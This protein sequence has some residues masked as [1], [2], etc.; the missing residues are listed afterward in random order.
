MAKL[1][2][3]RYTDALGIPEIAATVGL[4]PNYAM[5]L[6][7]KTFGMSML[8]YL[9]QHRLFH[10]RRLLATT[11][12]KVADVAFASGFGSLNRFYAIFQASD[13]CSPREYRK[14]FA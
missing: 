9:T 8:E 12:A 3:T 5:N 4:H 1:I 10:A 2:A 7:K 13:H 6:F 11:D 14:R